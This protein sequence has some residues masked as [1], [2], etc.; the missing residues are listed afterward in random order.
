MCV[1]WKESVCM[2]AALL[3]YTTVSCR[4]ITAQKRC[5][6]KKVSWN[7]VCAYLGRCGVFPMLQWQRLYVRAAQALEGHP[8]T[9]R[10]DTAHSDH[11]SPHTHQP[12]KH[13]GTQRPQRSQRF[14]VIEPVNDLHIKKSHPHSWS[15]NVKV[16]SKLQCVH[17]LALMWG[18]LMIGVATGSSS[19]CSS[20]ACFSKSIVSTWET[21][22]L[23][24]LSGAVPCFASPQ[25]SQIKVTVL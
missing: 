22:T 20:A 18:M 1:C 12:S 24:S 25:T 21:H 14:I 8:G 13:T 7:H 19:P 3:V 6:R 10:S 15:A 11:C 9:Q 23:V 2:C 4:N 5:C 17:Y 16:S